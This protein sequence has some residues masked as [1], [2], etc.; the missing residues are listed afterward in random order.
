M[1]FEKI[2]L[3]FSSISFALG[4]L[5][6]I[7]VAYFL[8][9]PELSVSN[10]TSDFLGERISVKGKVINIVERD[11][12]NYIIL[13]DGQKNLTIVIFPNVYK[14][15]KNDIKINQSVK[16]VGILSEYKGNLQIILQNPKNLIIEE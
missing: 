15:V 3:I 14:E 1:D 8:S 13:S 2:V 12:V 4:F 16:V 9:F 5:L 6:L 7:Y 11:R 10:V